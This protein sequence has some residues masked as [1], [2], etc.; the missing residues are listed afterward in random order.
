METIIKKYFLIWVLPI[1]LLLIAMLELPYG[2]YTFLRL[3]ITASSMV[4][5]W[6]LWK[7]QRMHKEIWS[8]IFL[9]IIALLYNPII[10]VHL[11]KQIWFIINIVT[12]V[13]YITSMVSLWK[14]KRQSY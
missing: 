13:L 4:I 9:T 7:Y 5:I 1:I 10:L 3:I 8:T 2:Y 11:S 14:S 12:I 6:L